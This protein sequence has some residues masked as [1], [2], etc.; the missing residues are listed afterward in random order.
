M[1]QVELRTM[2]LERLL[3]AE[4]LLREGRWSFAYYVA[5]YAVEC[6]LKSCVLARMIHTGGVFIDNK[7]SEHCL[8]HDFEQLIRSAGLTQ[9]LNVQLKASVAT[10]G[11]F[12]SHWNSVL[13]W[14]ETSRYEAK[15]EAEARTL[16]EA[17]SAQPNGV[18]QWIQQYW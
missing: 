17:I 3:D 14:K 9:E 8:T 6:A 7:I 12:T 16:H 15:T 4:A 18:L 2:A 11:V 13:Q 10:D 1:N 5:G